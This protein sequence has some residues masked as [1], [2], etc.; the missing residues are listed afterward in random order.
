MTNLSYHYGIYGAYQN[1][2]PGQCSSAAVQ[3]TLHG[4]TAAESSVGLATRL[5][6]DSS[7]YTT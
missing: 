4:V 2:L 6:I 1:C 7:K 3:H 5:A